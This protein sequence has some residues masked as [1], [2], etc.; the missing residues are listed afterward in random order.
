MK[1]LFI[2]LLLLQ[3][4]NHSFSQITDC[5]KAG[6]ISKFTTC[7]TNERYGDDLIPKFKNDFFTKLSPS[8]LN[9]ILGTDYPLDESIYP[10]YNK[11]NEF[12]YSLIFQSVNESSNHVKISLLVVDKC[13]DLIADQFLGDKH[14]YNSR[15]TGNA[16]H[17][18]FKFINDTTLEVNCQVMDY[19]YSNL[20]EDNYTYYSISKN[21]ISSIPNVSKNRINPVSLLELSSSEDV[22]NL[23][24][25]ER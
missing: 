21:D 13:G 3:T 17:F 20:I 12:G 11:V 10:C 24:K 14:L 16:K 5:R 18:Y 6:I 9:Y 25:P 19:T 15:E 8:F 7:N 22:L 2:I 23:P 4:F 1:Q